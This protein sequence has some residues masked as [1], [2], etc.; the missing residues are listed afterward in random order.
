[1]YFAN[2]MLYIVYTFLKV[3]ANYHQRINQNVI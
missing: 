2:I 3:R 1:M